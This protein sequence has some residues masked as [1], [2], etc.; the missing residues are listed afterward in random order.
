MLIIVSTAKYENN[1]DL[2]LR[3]QRSNLMPFSP[4]SYRDFVATLLAKTNRSLF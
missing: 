3:A 2:S 1:Y 4:A